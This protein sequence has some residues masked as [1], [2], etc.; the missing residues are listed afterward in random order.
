MITAV[1]PAHFPLAFHGHGS[2]GLAIALVAAFIVVLLLWSVLGGKGYLA[3]AIL[4]VAGLGSLSSSH[5][6]AH[7]SK[8]GRIAAAAVV[9]AIAAI[10]LLVSRW[11]RGRRAK[12][13]AAQRRPRA[14]A[15][16]GR[17]Q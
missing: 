5:V 13:S 9:V 11:L 12:K 15:Y 8:S 16:S 4:A 10:P 2:T 6:F 3:A 17:W 7:E 14:Q 1:H